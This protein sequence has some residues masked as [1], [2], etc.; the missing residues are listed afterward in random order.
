MADGYFVVYRD[1]VDSI[2]RAELNNK[3][4]ELAKSRAWLNVT[5]PNGDVHGWIGA[6]GID[7]KGSIK[8]TGALMVTSTQFVYG[9]SGWMDAEGDIVHP[10]E[11]IH[12]E[13]QKMTGPPSR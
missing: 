2:T 11:D 7:V 12:S 5:L 4:P 13:V 9:P 8:P 10:G 1:R 3:Y 6:Q